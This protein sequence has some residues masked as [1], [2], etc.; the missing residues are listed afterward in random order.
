MEPIIQ[1]KMEQLP[2]DLREEVIDFIDFLLTK[3]VLNVTVK[4]CHVVKNGI[5]V[6]KPEIQ[7]M[8]RFSCVVALTSVI[9]GFTMHHFLTVS[10][11]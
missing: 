6:D 10:Y 4:K 3:K 1:Q 5:T 8:S 7:S 9:S 11:N 2:P